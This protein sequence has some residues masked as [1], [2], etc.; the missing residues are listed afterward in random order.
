MSPAFKD[1][2]N[3]TAIAAAIL[4]RVYYLAFFIIRSSADKRQSTFAL[5]FS[6]HFHIAGLLFCSA[7]IVNI[8]FINFRP[9]INKRLFSFA[10][11]LLCF[12]L[13]GCRSRPARNNAWPLVKWFDRVSD[14][15]YNN[16]K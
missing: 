12:Q 11:Y 9:S 1:A 3:S 10:Q 6:R 16:V 13:H 7:V 14:E 15:E 4:V 5:L 8:A 2:L